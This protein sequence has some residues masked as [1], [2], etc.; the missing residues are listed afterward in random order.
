MSAPALNQ[1]VDAMQACV[2]TMNDCVQ[3][4][5]ALKADGLSV[6]QRQAIAR[7]GECQ[8]ALMANDLDCERETLAGMIEKLTEAA[9]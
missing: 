9:A 8:L 7:L 1:I 2:E 3:L 4:F 5:G 6:E